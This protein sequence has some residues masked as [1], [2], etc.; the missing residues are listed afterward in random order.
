MLEVLKRIY[1]AQITSRVPVLHVLKYKNL[2]RTLVIE[3][4]GMQK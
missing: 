2:R 3:V 4:S 1:V